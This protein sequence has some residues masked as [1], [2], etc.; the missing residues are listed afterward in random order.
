MEFLTFVVKG[1]ANRKKIM[2]IL[3]RNSVEFLTWVVMGRANR[4]K[5]IT[6]LSRNSV[7]FLQFFLRSFG[8]SSIREHITHSMIENCREIQRVSYTSVK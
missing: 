8:Y 5:I 2:T 6:I 7:E 1:S 4:K 3:S